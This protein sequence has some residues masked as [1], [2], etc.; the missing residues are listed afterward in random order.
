MDC[1]MEQ[2]KMLKWIGMISFSMTDLG[3]YLDTH[4]KETEAMEYYNHLV[5]LREQA[6]KDYTVNYGPLVLDRYK[7]EN[8]WCWA[9]QSWPWE[10]E[11]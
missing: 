3:L 11:C 2:H 9:T 4:P 7:T 10:G 1:R 8:H 5:K 6:I